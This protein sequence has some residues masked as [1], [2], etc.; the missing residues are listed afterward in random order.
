[1][2]KP[3]VQKRIVKKRTK[4][5]TRH[6]CE[7]FPQLSSSWRKPRGEDS[8]VR[9]RYKGQKAMPNKGY[10]SDRKTKYITPSGFKNFPIHNVQDLY[11]LLMQNRKYAGVISHTVGAKSRKAIVR[12]AHELDVRLINGNAKLRRCESH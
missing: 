6:K 3:F 9:R 8:P 10:G 2:V 11:M 7:L 4:R 12:K 1:M 5:F